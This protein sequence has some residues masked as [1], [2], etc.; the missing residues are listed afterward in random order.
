MLVSWRQSLTGIQ[1]LKAFHFLLDE[2]AMVP[3][4][5]DMSSVTFPKGKEC[6]FDCIQCSEEKVFM[7]FNYNKPDVSDTTSVVSIPIGLIY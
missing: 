1:V 5:G 7:Y 6:F 2:V 4:V 3:G